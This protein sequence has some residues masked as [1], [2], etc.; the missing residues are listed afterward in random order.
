MSEGIFDTQMLP[1]GICLTRVAKGVDVGLEEAR[2]NTQKVIELSGSS[3]PPLLVD[4]R[5][6]RS[7]S[8]EARDHFSMKGRTANVSAIALLIHSPV[9]R[10]IGNFYLG[11]SKPTV[12]TRLFTEEEKAKEWLRELKKK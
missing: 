1:E 5:F 10:V 11:L 2:W 9:S 7:I 8:K 4:I 3:C 12:P 6:I